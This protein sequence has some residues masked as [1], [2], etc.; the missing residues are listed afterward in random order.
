MAKGIV[1]RLVAGQ[2]WIDQVADAVQPLVNKL[3]SNAGE[4][5]R[6]AKDLLNGVWLGH[7]LHP[8]IT[9]VPVGAWT[10]AE[11]LDMASVGR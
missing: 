11:V 3:F 5:G 6:V 9:D 1:E 8:M 10:M 4:G 2:P 7:P